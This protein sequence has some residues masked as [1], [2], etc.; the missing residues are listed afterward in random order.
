V[1][2]PGRAKNRSALQP[3]WR[4]SADARA[5]LTQHL[6]CRRITLAGLRLGA[7]LAALS[8]AEEAVDGLLLWAP[9][10]KGRSYARE[11]KALSLTASAG[12][13]PAEPTNVIEAAGFVLTEQTARELGR[14]DLLQSRPHCGRVLILGAATTPRLTPPC[15]SITKPSGSTRNR[16]WHRGTPT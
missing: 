3:G 5:W 11:M 9:V 4:T 7:T 15:A 6:G 2:R 10:V 13:T 8:T 1:T 12:A 16:P 14:L